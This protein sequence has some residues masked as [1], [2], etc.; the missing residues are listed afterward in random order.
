MPTI[1]SYEWVYKH[2][3]CEFDHWDICLEGLINDNGEKKYVILFTNLYHDDKLLRYAVHKIDWNEQC[4]EYLKDYEI[5]YKHWFHVKGERPYGYDGEDLNWFEDK[6]KSNPI[7]ER[8][9][10]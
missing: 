6:W 4:D 2:L 3:I 5:A 9:V 7:L 8:Y 10:K 1:R